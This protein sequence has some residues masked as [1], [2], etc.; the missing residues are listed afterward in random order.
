MTNNVKSNINMNEVDH[1][2]KSQM[3]SM[4]L[5]LEK[6][7]KQTLK[8]QPDNPGT[9]VP[10]T[11]CED[12]PHKYSYDIIHYVFNIV[13]EY[14]SK[15]STQHDL[16]KSKSHIIE[17]I[18]NKKTSAVALL[19]LVRDV[20]KNEFIDILHKCISNNIYI[21]EDFIEYCLDL[22]KTIVLADL[23]IQLMELIN[24]MIL[25]DYDRFV[26]YNLLTK[27][28]YQF[29]ADK[30]SY[31]EQLLLYKDNCLFF[32]TLRN[33]TFF[34]CF[35]IH[36]SIVKE[37]IMKLLYNKKSDIFK[38]SHYLINDMPLLFQ[39][40][41]NRYLSLF[42]D[43][44]L[45]YHSRDK[46]INTHLYIIAE[47]MIMLK[48]LDEAFEILSNV[49]SYVGDINGPLSFYD[50]DVLK[51]NWDLTINKS[52]LLNLAK[53][54][55]NEKAIHLLMSNGAKDPDIKLMEFGKNK[56]ELTKFI[57]RLSPQ[58]Y[59]FKKDTEVNSV[60]DNDTNVVV[61]TDVD[62]PVNKPVDK[63]VNKP[64]NGWLSY[65]FNTNDKEKEKENMKTD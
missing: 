15:Y 64:S 57:N 47:C 10:L 35:G 32:N 48:D 56:E 55:G 54:V 1:I 29:I 50:P 60:I 43:K 46:L 3:S 7:I 17:D 30:K 25:K 53:A 2:D 37:T 41:K 49:I 23:V 40:G 24:D 20:T 61:I 11:G 22:N 21:S 42:N 33:D 51:S 65:L 44:K 13:L 27:C 36:K 16:Q 12:I 5:F 9:K 62:K 26:I 4:C 63:P 39:Y 6:M 34:G 18:I 59:V 38:T 45:I 14:Y 28:Y 8:P 58:S 19:S 31:P 52:S